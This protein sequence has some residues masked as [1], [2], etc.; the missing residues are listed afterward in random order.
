VFADDLRHS[1]EVTLPE[2]RGRGRLQR[3][4]EAVAR[5]FEFLL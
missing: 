4:R 5:R 2:W 3:L 1:A